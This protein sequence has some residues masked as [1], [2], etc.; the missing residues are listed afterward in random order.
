[1]PHGT[2]PPLLEKWRSLQLDSRKGSLIG[3]SSPPTMGGFFQ[4]ALTVRPSSTG[5]TS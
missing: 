3:E 5:Q 1:M 4:V 2:V